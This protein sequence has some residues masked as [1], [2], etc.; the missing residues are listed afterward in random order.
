MG[1]KRKKPVE[2]EKLSYNLIVRISEREREVLAQRAVEKGYQD[3]TKYCRS[4][5]R[6]AELRNWS[7]LNRELKKIKYQISNLESVLK[8]IEKNA[9]YGSYPVETQ[10]RFQECVCQMQELSKKLEELLGDQEKNG[11]G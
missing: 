6:D 5:L 11:E 4:L 10:H 3:T 1:R 9:I 7:D 8:Q 2:S